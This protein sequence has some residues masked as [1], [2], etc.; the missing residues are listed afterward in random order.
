MRSPPLAVLAT[1]LLC[2]PAFAA[3]PLEAA[4]VDYET[5]PV[6]IFQND[7]RY[8][9]NGTLYTA[10][11]VGQT[12]TLFPAMRMT[13]DLRFSPK[14]E[15]VLLYAPLELNTR[16]T[17]AQPFQFRGTLF[18]SGPVAHRYL[19]DG[20]RASYLYGLL[21]DGPLKLQVGGSFQIRNASVEF[22]TLDGTLFDRETDIGL[23]FAFKARLRYDHSSGLWAMLDADGFS[24]FGLGVKGAIYDVALTLGLPLTPSADLFFRLRYL[25]GGAEVPSRPLFNWGN[26]GFAL[27]GARLDLVRLLPQR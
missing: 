8:G 18:P 22:A 13:V 26:F 9:E 21:T 7:G 15:V 11:D 16:A 4:V 5:G 6:R 19:F 27:I 25:G 14:H 20:Y 23:V 12:Q 17:L 10:T 3:G 2:L 1:F 24:S